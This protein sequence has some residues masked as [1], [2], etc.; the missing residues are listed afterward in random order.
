MKVL[1]SPRSTHATT[2]GKRR[3]ASSRVGVPASKT[4]SKD[5]E[6]PH[7]PL[8][9]RLKLTGRGLGGHRLS[10]SSPGPALAE[11]ARLQLP[12]GRAEGTD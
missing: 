1:R 3:R 10:T 4:D 2:F 9:C 8:R 12:A 11:L 5:D 7:L 6:E